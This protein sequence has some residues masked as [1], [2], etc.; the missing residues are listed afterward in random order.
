MTVDLH[1]KDQGLS[2]WINGYILTTELSPNNE[3]I[4]TVYIDLKRGLQS[5]SQLKERLDYVTISM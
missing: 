4:P 1:D 3:G 2:V 5:S